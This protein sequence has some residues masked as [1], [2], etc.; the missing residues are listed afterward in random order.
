MTASE[1][2][3]RIF[4]IAFSFREQALHNLHT[5]FDGRLKRR[6][7]YGANHD[8][9]ENRIKSQV[10]LFV[11][12]METYRRRSHSAHISGGVQASFHCKG[13]QR[14]QRARQHNLIGIV[15]LEA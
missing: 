10:L 2:K 12:S 6:V 14:C 15:T 3:D 8:D 4:V 11:T 13:S 7:A 1:A 5:P 9:D